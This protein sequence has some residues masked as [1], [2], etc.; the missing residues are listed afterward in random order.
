MGKEKR[1]IVV[2]VVKSGY[3]CEW[4]CST[5]RFT[6]YYTAFRWTKIACNGQSLDPPRRKR[7][8]KGWSSLRLEHVDLA[9]NFMRDHPNA[10]LREIVVSSSTNGRGLRSI[11]SASSISIRLRGVKANNFSLLPIHQGLNFVEST[12]EAKQGPVHSCLPLML[13]MGKGM[14][15]VVFALWL[16][17]FCR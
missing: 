11:S 15:W 10:Y 8:R 3:Y 7:I 4:S 6:I 5:A 2:D 14:R 16:W 12:T 17:N 1:R 9:M 13:L